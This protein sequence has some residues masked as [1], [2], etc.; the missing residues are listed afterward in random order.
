M[1]ETLWGGAIHDDCLVIL[2]V[3]LTCAQFV[4]CHCHDELVMKTSDKLVMNTSDQ[5]V[6]KTILGGCA[7]SH[8]TDHLINQ[9]VVLVGE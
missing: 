1:V 3:V 4:R 6:M 8:P 2:Q 7:W 9:Q 5:L